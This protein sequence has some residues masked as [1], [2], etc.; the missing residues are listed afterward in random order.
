MILGCG[1]STGLSPYA[2]VYSGTWVNIDDSTDQGTSNWTIDLDGKVN[3]QDNDPGRETTFDVEGHIDNNG[4]LVS[5]STPV[6]GSPAS[7]NGPMHLENGK[8]VGT[9]TWGVDPVS[10]YDYVLTPQF[11]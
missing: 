10:H 1:G 11:N 3:G 2:N 9:L 6:D 8:L 7:L 4:N 5:T